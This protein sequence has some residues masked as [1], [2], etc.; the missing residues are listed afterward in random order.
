METRQLNKIKH[1]LEAADLVPQEYSFS[2]SSAPDKKL[3][4]KKFT[5]RDR[6]QVNAKWSQAEVEAIFA[7]LKQKELAEIAYMLLK[8]K[9]IFPDFDAFTEAVVS[10]ADMATLIRGVMHTIGVSEPLIDELVEKIPGPKA[11]AR[12]PKK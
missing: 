5:L 1:T 3:T 8:E 11:K 9:D 2:L 10:M 4:L 7:Q 12:K 6:L